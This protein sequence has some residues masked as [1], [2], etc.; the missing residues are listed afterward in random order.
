MLVIENQHKLV[1]NTKKFAAVREAIPHAKVFLHKGE[2]LVAV[3]HGVEEAIVLK[4]MGFKAVPSPVLHYY[5]WPGRVMPMAHQKDTTAFLVMHR[6]A[7]CLNAPGTGKSLSALWAMDYLLSTQVI[8]KVLIIAPLSTLKPVWAKEL[9]HH[10]G[11][12]NFEILVG[13]RSKREDLLEKPGLQ[14][15]IINHDGFSIMP[16]A[17]KDFDLVIYDEATALKSPTSQRFKKFVHFMNNYSPWLWMLTGTPIA[18]NPTDAWAL[19]KLVNSKTLPRSFSAFK[20]A[21]MQKISQFKWIPRSEALDICK[22]V[23]QPSIRYDLA[24]CKDLPETSFIDVQCELTDDQAAAYKEMREEACI[25]GADISAANAAVLF[26][27]LL[28]I[29][30]GVAYN[31]DREH[32]HFDDAGRLGTLRELLDEIGDKCI[33]YVPLRGVQERLQFVLSSEGY[34]VVSVHGDVSKSDR[35][36]I[37]HKFQNTDEIKILLAHPKVAAHGLTLTRAK[38]IIWYAPIYSLEMYE[39]ANAR[40]KRLTTVG[41]TVVYHIYSTSFE[42][43]LYKRLKL[44]QRVLTDFLNL[45]RGVNE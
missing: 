23:M 4:N 34:D 11:H 31:S 27:K 7:L 21:T 25:A 44:K 38:H 9:V 12:L 29:C 6:K 43:E 5:D 8:Q 16:N 10:F 3:E 13:N 26:G 32:V 2:T 19:A 18:Q 30:C 37:F 15:A 20:D 39:Q 41:K 33:V 36:N 35:D 1:I 40:I 28:Q 17:F 24:Q 45:V 14:V 42:L 22:N